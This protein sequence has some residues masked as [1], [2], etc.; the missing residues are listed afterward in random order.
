MLKKH[1]A[2]PPGNTAEVIQQLKEEL[3]VEKELRSQQESEVKSLKE[4]LS[5]I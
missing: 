5:I 2:K 1:N 3:K 4:K